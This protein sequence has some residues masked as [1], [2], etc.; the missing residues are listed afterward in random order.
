MQS[1]WDDGMLLCMGGFLPSSPPGAL[2]S[3]SASNGFFFRFA[4]MQGGYVNGS[5]GVFIVLTEA[6]YLMVV[7]DGMFLKMVQVSDIPVNS[8]G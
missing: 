3:T 8:A 5:L 6:G 7:Q 1:D 2:L 4:T